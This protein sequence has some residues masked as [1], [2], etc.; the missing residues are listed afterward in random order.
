M[1]LSGGARGYPRARARPHLRPSFPRFA[2]GGATISVR[3]DKG[4]SESS[5]LRLY[6]GRRLVSE[7]TA[8]PRRP[9]AR[10]KRG[11]L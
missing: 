8:A 7:F 4:R 3:E 10:R 9:P 11:R 2:P 5:F 6:V 1:S